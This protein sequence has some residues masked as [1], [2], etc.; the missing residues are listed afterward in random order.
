MKKKKNLPWA[1]ALALLKA[2]NKRFVEDKLSNTGRNNE[3]RRELVNGQ[4][5]HSI[6]LGCADSRVVPEV[7]FDAGLGEV[8]VVRPAGNVANKVSIASIEYAVA[9]IGVNLIV[10]MG[11]QSCGAVKAT[12]ETGSGSTGSENL[13][14]LIKFIRPAVQ[15]ASVDKINEVVKRNAKLSAKSLCEKSKIIQKAVKCSDL[16][17]LTAY[18]H[19]TTGEIDFLDVPTT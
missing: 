1:E 14:H 10:V 15:G 12:I 19:L 11:H 2:G 17:I 13:D 8:F 4:T 3:R 18:Y 9:E 7:A 6:I 16:K 5:P